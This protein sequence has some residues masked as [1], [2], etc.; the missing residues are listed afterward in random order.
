MKT[1]AFIGVIL[2]AAAPAALCDP[3][4]E[5]SVYV[6]PELGSHIGGGYAKS[7][8]SKIQTKAITNRSRENPALGKALSALDAQAG[9]VVQGY[10]LAMT[11]VSLQTKVPVETL[12]KQ[13]AATGLSASDLLVADSLA[14]GSGRS[15]EEVLA[16]QK[17]TGVWTP[18]VSQLGIDLKSIVAR[19]RAA[20]SSVRYAEARNNRQREQNRRDN[21]LHTRTQPP[22]N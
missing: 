6:P 3:R 22:G 2:L 17:R 13:Q 11:A 4:S 12:R 16:M 15:F 7:G 21:D 5:D 1:I 18:L 20:E 19:A 9:T 10:A 8:R 14:G